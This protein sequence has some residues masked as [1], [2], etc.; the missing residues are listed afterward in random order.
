M[1]ALA[2]REIPRELNAISACG[3]AGSSGQDMQAG[4]EAFSSAP[5]PYME[6]SR[7]HNSSITHWKQLWYASTV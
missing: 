6:E 4:K 7:K 1:A 2:N 3:A 5:F